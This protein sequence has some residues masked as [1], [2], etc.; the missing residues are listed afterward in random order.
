[1]HQPCARLCLFGLGFLALDARAQPPTPSRAPANGRVAC[2][3]LVKAR[4]G[5]PLSY[6][7]RGDRCEGV[8]AQDVAS[9]SSLLVASVIESFE[10]IDDTSSLP[11]RV[12]WTSPNG[13]AVRLRAYSIR[14]GLYY[15]METT[16]PIAESPYLWPPGVI[17]ALRIG[18][19]DIGV[20]GSTFPAL[21]GVR[22]EVLVPLRIS[23]RKTPARSST[24]R[25]TVWPS[26]ELSDVFVTVAT[27][28]SSGKPA[29][30]LQR[31]ENLAYGFYPAER[32][33]V[34][35]LKP[36]AARGIYFVRIAA[37]LKRGGS[38]TSTFLLFHPGPPTATGRR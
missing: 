19:A 15:R 8:Y 21:N 33:V 34:V 16:Q 14:S 6:R 25:V 9:R 26:V 28:D 36:L 22:S 5:D 2:D 23:H 18:N 7:Q 32:G 30:Y 31:D 37:T 11:L 1:M 3:S 24:Y 20:T 35:P 27:A 38:A 4:P 13:E 10:A 17:Q 12:E 29:T